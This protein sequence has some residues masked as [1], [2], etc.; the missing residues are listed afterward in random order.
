MTSDPAPR[1]FVFGLGYSAQVFARRLRAR[2]W[3]VAGTTR[4]P[5]AATALR[6]EGIEALL[7]ERTRPLSAP[8]AA[9][10]GTSHL[11]ASVPPDAAGDPVLDLHG[12]DIA[13]CASIAWAGYLS[14]TGVYGDRGGDWVDEDSALEPT[15]PRSTRRLAAERAW[16]E[17]Q[18][19]HGL[20]VHVFRLAGIYGPGRCALDQARAGT[21][22]RIDKPGQVF[23]RIHVDDIATVLEASIA[24]PN[25][26]RAYNL[27]DDSP[28]PP[29]EVVARACALLGLE[30]PPLVP[31]EAA[32]LSPMARSFYRDNKRVSN[33]RIKEELR[34]ALA[35]PDYQSGLAAIQAA[36]G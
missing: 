28:A 29:A 13:A 24:R 20:P 2:G 5:E 31:Y 25:P 35:Y 11:L 10:A 30:P 36:G 19:R 14:T 22:R 9:L 16:L 23:S 17:L 15:G 3:R 26:G 18:R 33:R 32:A 6:A 8:A 34:V 1:L 21:A 4:S 12:P 7:F 27:C